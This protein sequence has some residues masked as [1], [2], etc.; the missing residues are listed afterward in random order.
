MG[1]KAADGYH[2]PLLETTNKSIS[3]KDPPAPL[4]E[5]PVISFWIDYGY[6]LIHSRS[7]ILCLLGF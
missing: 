3:R 4:I 5:R 7:Y 1:S 2:S 6:P